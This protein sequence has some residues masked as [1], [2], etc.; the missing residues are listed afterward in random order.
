MYNKRRFAKM[1]ATYADD[2]FRYI[3]VRVRDEMLAEDL[4]ADTFSKAWQKLETFDFRQPRAWLYTIAR[5]LI[6][7][8]WRTHHTVPLEAGFDPED[9]R[10]P[11]E[12]QVERTLSK[13]KLTA[14]IGQ[15]PEVM[16][17]VVSLR[18]LQGFSAR[19]TGDALGIAEGN[20]RII[21]YRA[22]KKLKGILS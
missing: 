10:E 8:H 9:D 6:T 11:V 14:A 5:N 16:Q 2:I 13:D 4:T 3:Y 18:F 19:Q 7:D 20:V 12:A 15:L 17:S 21:Q 1:Y 22:L